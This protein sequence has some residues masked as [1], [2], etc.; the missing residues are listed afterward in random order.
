MQLSVLFYFVD[1]HFFVD[2][3]VVGINYCVIL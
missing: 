1:C 2:H 3:V